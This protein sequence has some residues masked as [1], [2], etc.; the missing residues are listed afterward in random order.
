LALK[1][2]RR[3]LEELVDYS[4]DVDEFLTVNEFFGFQKRKGGTF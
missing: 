3:G 4:L 2:E 1:K